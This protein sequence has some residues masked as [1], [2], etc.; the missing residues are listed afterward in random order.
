MEKELYVVASGVWGVHSNPKNTNDAY[1]DCLKEFDHKGCSFDEYVEHDDNR[2]EYQ[3]LKE[4]ADRNPNW[5]KID[6]ETSDLDGMHVSGT[7]RLTKN[8]AKELG[9]TFYLYKMKYLV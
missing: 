7:V 6:P 5:F 4:I 2:V 3:T 8:Q 9:Y 1:I